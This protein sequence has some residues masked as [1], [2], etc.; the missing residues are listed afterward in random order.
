MLKP[1]HRLIRRHAKCVEGVSYAP[2]CPSCAASV[3]ICRRKLMH[4]VHAL[5]AS[6][7]SMTC[8]ARVDTQ[9]GAEQKSQC[10][11]RYSVAHSSETGTSLHR[12]QATIEIFSSMNKQNPLTTRFMPLRLNA[13]LPGKSAEVSMNAAPH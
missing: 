7:D 6:P 5:A 8:T 4:E 3:H 1:T 13:S 12:K 11:C 9:M 2:C 10:D